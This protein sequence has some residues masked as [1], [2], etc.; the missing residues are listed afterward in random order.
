[1]KRSISVFFTALLLTAFS[2]GAS[3]NRTEAAGLEVGTKL[4][5]IISQVTQANLLEPV[6]NLATVGA[7]VTYEEMPSNDQIELLKNLGFQ[8]KTFSQLPMVA[9]SGTA[10]QIK[11]LLSSGLDARSIYYNKDLD[12]LSYTTGREVIRAD[13]VARELG[14][15]GKGVTVAV[16]DSGI[17]A[18]HPDL[19]FGE[20]VIQNVKFLVGGGLFGTESIYLENVIDTD[21]TSGHGTHVAGIIAGNGSASGGVFKGVAPDAKLVGLG[22]GEGINIFWALAA[23]NYALEHQE[24]YNIQ[25]IS[26]SYGTTGEYSPDAPINVASKKAHDAG[27]VVTFAAGNAGPD[28]NTLNPFSVA[29]WVISVAAGTKDKQLADFSSRGVPGSKRLHPDITAP[30]VNIVSARAKTGL[31]GLTGVTTDVSYLE[32][33][34]IPYYTTLS[35]TSMATPEISGVAALMLEA[36]PNLTPDQVLDILKNT[37]DP[38]EGYETYEVGAGYAD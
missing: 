3:P 34:Y 36:N 25:V 21:T 20:K 38:M 31:V 2:I 14:Y 28:Q 10:A 12:Y 8:T 15:T 35:G 17:D 9:I 23:F 29:P 33:Q 26:N 11:H 37:A 1:M 24:E 16:I 27:M 4:Q 5:Q 32:P 22:V 19:P 30:G 6:T 13:E 18:T 7:V